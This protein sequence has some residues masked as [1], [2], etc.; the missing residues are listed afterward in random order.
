MNA[1]EFGEYLERCLEDYI[2][3]G[4]RAT[5]M[6]LEEATEFAHK[7]IAELLPDGHRTKGHHILK[8]LRCD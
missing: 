7:Q 8:L 6:P 1:D 4:A 2:R 3:D 5:S